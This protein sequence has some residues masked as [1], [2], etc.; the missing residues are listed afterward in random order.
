MARSIAQPE[1]TSFYLVSFTNLVT[2]TYFAKF[3]TLDSDYVF[4]GQEYESE[5]RMTV[6]FPRNDG[7]LG[8]E[9]AVITLPRD[10][11]F[12]QDVT[13]GLRYP[14]TQ[15]RVTEIIPGDGAIS[16]TVLRPFQGLMTLARRKVGGKRGVVSIQ[17]LS[18]K[19]RL[20]Q[21]ALGLPCMQNCVNR[22]GDSSCKVAMNVSPKRLLNV[23]VVAVDGPK[24]TLL[25]SE[26]PS[27]LEDRFYQRGYLI[28]DGFEF[29]IRDWRNEVEGDKAEFFLFRRPPDS[30]VGA[31]V[32]V[33]SG[34]DK[35]NGTCDSRY[36][37]IANFKGAGAKMPAYNPVYEDGAAR[38]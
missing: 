2:N 21:V 27:G 15:V 6:T 34:C 37:N 16:T 8:E 22:L 13:T 38:Q 7:T 32:T 29:E 12:A 3:T 9:P 25:T 24:V 4:E 19:S 11:Q 31:S 20:Q 5:T 30:W 26:I 10:L 18:I 1:K 28:L 33:F 23:N 35:T 36:G 14:A 17:A